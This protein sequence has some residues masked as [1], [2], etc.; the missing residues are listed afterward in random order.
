MSVAAAQAD[1]IQEA[2]AQTAISTEFGA[3]ALTNQMDL[4]RKNLLWP[5]FRRRP[6]AV[7]S[8]AGDVLDGGA[9]HARGRISHRGD[10]RLG[11]IGD[12][13]GV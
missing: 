6:T 8:E 10:A 2:R 4:V 12:L 1:L 9:L 3:R 13:R 7:T 11:T 5:G